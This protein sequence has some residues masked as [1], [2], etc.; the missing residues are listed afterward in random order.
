VP[1]E[2]VGGRQAPQEGDELAAGAALEGDEEQAR[3]DL[4]AAGFD[5]FAVGV[6]ASQNA[7]PLVVLRA[8]ETVRGGPV[9]GSL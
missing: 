1:V 4:P 9:K 2:R 7:L 3:V 5:A 8:S 6:A